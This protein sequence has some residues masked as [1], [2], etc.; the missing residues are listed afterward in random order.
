M[1]LAAM[2]RSPLFRRLRRLARRAFHGDAPRER[3]EGPSRRDMLRAAALLPLAAAACGDDATSPTVAIIGGGIAGLT[4]CHFLRESGLRADVY[5]ASMRLGGRMFTHSGAP[6]QGGQICELGGELVDTDHVTIQALCDLFGIVLDDLPAVTSTLKQDIFHFN[7]AELSEASI[8]AAFTP[9]AD[10][11]GMAV[12]AGDA[13]DTEFARIDA[14]SIPQWLEQ[15]AGL[16]AGNLL[17]ELL[18]LAY[19]EEFGLEPGEQ[20]AWNLITLID[21]ETPDPFH[22]FGDSD[23]RFHIHTGSGSL[24]EAIAEQLTDRIN[25]DHAL[26]KVVAADGRFT[27]TFANGATATADHIVY[28]LPFTKLR[29]ADLSKAGLSADKKTTINELGYGTN[30]KL[31]LQFS[32]R[33]WETNQSSNGSVITDVG[34]LQ[35]TWQTTRGQTG[36]Q[37]ILTN[38]VGGTRGVEIGTGTAESQAQMV[39]P[40]IETIFPGTQAT[41]IPNTAIRQHWPSYE[42]TKGSYAS[43][44]VGQ[45]AFFGT[46]GARE[47]NQH[48]CG[49]HCSENFQGYMEGGAETGALVAAEI[50]DD[51]NRSY[52]PL[53]KTLIDGLTATPRASYHRGFGDRMK[54]AQIRR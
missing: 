5:E 1:I 19:T 46:E 11:M 22:V 48:F 42:F 53:L 43:Y 41:Y 6:L 23:E 26:T 21:Y 10:K 49:E 29:E 8:V 30:A 33:P 38:F 7:G 52:S 40:W 12:A 35:S 32:S 47:G 51:S 9:V 36:A 16:P 45:W 31:M 2:A 34:Q 4:V 3:R 17:R 50:L 24:P 13:D 39:L 37:G 20:S 54:L 27:L 44:L 18:E 14:M 25:F 28:A 15:E